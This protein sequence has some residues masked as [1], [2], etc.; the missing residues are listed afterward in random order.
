MFIFPCGK[1]KEP[2]MADFT[3]EELLKLAN[4][5]AIK[6]DEQETTLFTEQIKT[7][8]AFTEQLQEVET[9]NAQERIRNVNT[10]R[11]DVARTSPNAQAVIE[12]SPK[13]E[14]NY[15]VVPKILD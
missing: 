1:P 9:D 4:L 2:S 14:L 12:Q 8:L 15:F 5:S 7:I 3:K 11:Q 10:I 13:E 6:L